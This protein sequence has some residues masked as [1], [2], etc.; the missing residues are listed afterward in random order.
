MKKLISKDNKYLKEIKHYFL[1]LHENENLSKTES[2]N[3]AEA[4][5]NYLLDIHSLKNEDIYISTKGAIKYLHIQLSYENMSLDK[6]NALLKYNDN[7]EFKSDFYLAFSLI[8]RIMFHISL[9]RHP[10]Y[11]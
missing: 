1:A 9:E 4:Y 7:K 10:I 11:L 5:L 3:L 2:R 6:N 8:N